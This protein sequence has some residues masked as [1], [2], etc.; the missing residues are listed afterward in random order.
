[1]QYPGQTAR[2]LIIN[3][4]ALLILTLT[5]DHCFIVPGHRFPLSR[6]PRPTPGP[7]LAHHTLG[8]FYR[9]VT[10]LPVT[11]EFFVS[12]IPGPSLLRDGSTKG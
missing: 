8:V 2:R 10:L 6:P 4:S 7:V 3:H 12:R 11:P 1:M 9:S 5:T